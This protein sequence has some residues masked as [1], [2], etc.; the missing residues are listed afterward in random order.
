MNVTCCAGPI[1]LG[2]ISFQ[3]P[4]GSGRLQPA[5][6]HLLQRRR[7]LRRRDGGR[8][9]GGR[10]LLQALQ[11]RRNRLL[12]L[13]LQPQDGH[14]AGQP[15]GHRLCCAVRL[16]LQALQR[17]FGRRGRLRALTGSSARAVH[18][19]ALRFETCPAACLHRAVRLL[20][21]ALQRRHGAGAHTA[22]GGE[23]ISYTEPPPAD[24]G[25]PGRRDARRR[26][27]LDGLHCL[28]RISLQDRQ[29]RILNTRNREPGSAQGP[30]SEAKF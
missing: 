17:R 12:C 9:D 13:L 7:C 30:V 14:A 6:T 23:H 25:E 24:L 28:L 2:A 16:L 4:C 27:G 22:C 8:L 21:Q 1:Q 5:A 20:Q 3:P 18:C 19:T 15:L 29:V 11:R 10:L 26:S